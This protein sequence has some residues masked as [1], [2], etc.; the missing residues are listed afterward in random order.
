VDTYFLGIAQCDLQPVVGQGV[1]SIAVAPGQRLGRHQCV[2]NRLFCGKD[3]RLEEWL[4]SASVWVSPSAALL[5]AALLRAA[6]V[7]WRAVTVW[8]CLSL[9]CPQ[10]AGG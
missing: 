3:C 7:W 1:D 8:A 4:L 6:V 5:R 2:D 9:P 10:S